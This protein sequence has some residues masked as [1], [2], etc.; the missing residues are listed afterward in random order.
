MELEKATIVWPGPWGAH[1][2]YPMSFNPS[3]GLVYFAVQDAP[4]VYP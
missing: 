3:S 2:W 1:N 4:F